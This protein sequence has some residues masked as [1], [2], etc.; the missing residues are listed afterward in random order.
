MLSRT[1]YD[2]SKDPNYRNKLAKILP[3]MDPARR[4]TL[5]FQFGR[6]MESRIEYGTLEDYE[7]GMKPVLGDPPDYSASDTRKILKQL[8]RPVL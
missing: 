3:G 5:M 8:F 2:L 1:A 6:L 7:R 4:N